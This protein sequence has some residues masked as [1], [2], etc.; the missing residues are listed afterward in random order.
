MI[1]F[2][3]TIRVRLLLLAYVVYGK[4]SFFIFAKGLIL[5]EVEEVSIL[6]HFPRRTIGMESDL[7][8]PLLEIL[9]LCSRNQPI[10]LWD[11]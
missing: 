7:Q 1:I 3:I 4:C 8:P 10:S 9:L 6:H 2:S 5:E 11:P